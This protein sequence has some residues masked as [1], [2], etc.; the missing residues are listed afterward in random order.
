QLQ[1]VAGNFQSQINTLSTAIGDVRTEER[2]GIAAAVAIAN[3]PT[4]SAPGKTTVAVN[5]GFFQG[6][7]GVGIGFAHRLNTSVPVIVSGAYG[8]GGG[9][10][11]IGRAG[12]AVEF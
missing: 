3:S 10:T 2:R 8:N 7:T 1:G 9:D 6:Q 11:H 12:V 4:P 5:T